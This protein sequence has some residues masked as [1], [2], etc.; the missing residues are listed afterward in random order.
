MTKKLQVF[1]SS[2]YVDLIPERQAVVQAIL[3]AG[4]IPAGMELFSAGSET[5]W[6]V[7]QRWIRDCDVYMLILG[8]R[9][10]SC[11][12]GSDKSYTELEFDFAIEQ[13]KPHFAVV[14]S[15]EAVVERQ[16]SLGATADEGHLAKHKLGQFRER[17]TSTKI[18]RMVNN[19]DQ[20]ELAVVH[21]LRSLDHDANIRGWVR[22]EG[23]GGLVAEALSKEISLLRAENT[24]LKGKLAKAQSQ[25]AAYGPSGSLANIQSVRTVTS[26]TAVEKFLRAGWTV[27]STR[28][29]R[30]GGETWTAYD[31][32]WSKA[33]EPRVPNGY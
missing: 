26:S 29:E 16:A 17:I 31:L 2:T 7:I 18:T 5:Q 30:D 1:V 8:A 14:L 13:S 27:L 10:G 21:A 24:E 33:E 6:E 28:T 22:A 15:K 32:A 25:L 9:Y 4:H 20:A 19:A 12:E 3:A 11:P 23:S